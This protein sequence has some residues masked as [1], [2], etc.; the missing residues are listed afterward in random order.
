MII[1]SRFDMVAVLDKPVPPV[2]FVSALAFL[3][4]VYSDFSAVIFTY[5]PG[6]TGLVAPRGE[7]DACP[8]KSQRSPR[9]LM[10]E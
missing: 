10:V 3:F 1:L 2:G 5:A 8:A 9:E 6:A 4:T 7:G